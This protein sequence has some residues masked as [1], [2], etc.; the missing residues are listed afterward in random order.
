MTQLLVTACL[1]SCLGLTVDVTIVDSSVTITMIEESQEQ[2]TISCTAEFV[3][4][5]SPVRPSESK[6]LVFVMTAPD[7]Y[8]MQDVVLWAWR[9]IT[10]LCRS[11]VE[12][13]ADVF[14]LP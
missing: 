4:T 1:A 12:A 11:F 9:P 2:Q 3:L 5:A 13:P 6:W 7:A 14:P 8:R 10:C